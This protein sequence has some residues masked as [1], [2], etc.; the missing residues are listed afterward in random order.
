MY[1]FKGCV[2]GALCRE[3]IEPLAGITLKF[4]RLA[5]DRN[6][7]ALAVASAKDTFT[8]VDDAAIKAR[9]SLFL[10]ETVIDEKGIFAVEFPSAYEGEAFEVDL[11]CGTVPYLKPGPRP[12]VPLQFTITTLQPMWRTVEKNLVAAWEY[13]VPYRYWC[14]IRGRFGAWT[15]CGYVRLCSNQA[16]IGGVRV[17]AFDVDWLQDD[18]LGFAV[19]DGSGHFR[20]DYSAA[21]FKKTIFSPAINI[22]WT[23][24]PDLYFKVETLS[25][26]VLL[27]EPP[28]RGRAPDRE[29]VGPC[30]CVDLCLEKQPPTN[31]YP[32]VFDALGGYLY[33]T[34]IRSAVPGSGLTVADN[35]AFYSTVRLNGALS[36]T[37][38][39]LPMEYRFEFRTTDSSGNPTG[40]W[41]PITPAQFS[42]TIIGKREL[43]APAFLGDPNPIKTAYVLADPANLGGGPLNAAIV[44]G[45]IQ[46]PQ[47]SNVFGS[48][49]FFVPNG[50]MINAIT[51]SLVGSPGINVLG[52]KAGQ[53]STALGAP[54]AQNRHIALRMRVREIGIPASEVD[55]GT[56][57]HVAIE[58][59]LYAGVAKGG[60]WAPFTVNDQLCVC[61]VDALQLRAN[62]CAGVHTGLDVVF[63]TTH[64]NL[65]AVDIT[66]TGP[67]GPYGFTL[68]AAVPGERFGT[69]TNSFVFSTL[70]DC[71][72]II[73]LSA[74]L[75]LTTGDSSPLPV[76]DEVAFC[77]K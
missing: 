11:Y 75:L 60:S 26:T 50:N 73:K 68:P 12:P 62:G 28:S 74:A 2:R 70:T 16:P 52:V 5:S 71:A 47:W 36:K 27:A 72:Y 54:L 67:G 44:G 14:G 25:G 46:V 38:N 42:A 20:I 69:A 65:G 22:E 61:S 43:Y 45:W 3:C 55:A 56:C 17:R 32:P 51:S 19:T 59:T 31:D 7:T 33:A 30:F 49:G 15:I 53:S 39:S 1:I 23:G 66:M 77:K 18:A 64:P 24:G 63:T 35:R 40:A 10:A 21:D 9:K 8:P 13:T 76:T 4:Y 29:N 41:T 48:E 34:D 6:V 58:N 37:L 57:F